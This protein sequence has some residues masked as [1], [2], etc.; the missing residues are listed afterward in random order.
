MERQ[1]NFFERVAVFSSR[2]LADKFMNKHFGVW[3]IVET[4]LDSEKDPRA[5]GWEK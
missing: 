5:I 1:T 3:V 4:E 2:A